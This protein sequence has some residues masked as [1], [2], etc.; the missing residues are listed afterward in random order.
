[1]KEAS[2]LPDQ[3]HQQERKGREKVSDTS[4]SRLIERGSV[5]RIFL[6]NTINEDGAL[7]HSRPSLSSSACQQAVDEKRLT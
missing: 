1:M 5:D 3:E 6:E 2:H 7:D 4:R